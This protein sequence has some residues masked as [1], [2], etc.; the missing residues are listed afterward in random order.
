MK[1]VIDI[2]AARAAASSDRAYQ[3]AQMRQP[4]PPAI[5]LDQEQAQ[6]LAFAMMAYAY[7]RRDLHAG[8]MDG[9]SNWMRMCDEKLV[10]VFG[11]TGRQIH[12]LGYGPIDGDAA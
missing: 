9:F 4:P 2:T 3:A 1:D 7:A 6:G 8:D 11:L 10:A 12:E 5:A